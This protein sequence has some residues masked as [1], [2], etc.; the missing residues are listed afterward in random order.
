MKSRARLSAAVVVMA[1]ALQPL[2]T[3]RAAQPSGSRPLPAIKPAT[4]STFATGPASADAFLAHSMLAR[5][6]MP[7]D[8]AMRG[9][10]F[11]VQRFGVPL[12]PDEQEQLEG[13]FWW[14]VAFGVMDA[15]WRY[16]SSR[17]YRPR[18]WRYWGG[19]ATAAAIGGTVGA[20][21]GGYASAIRA[22]EPLGRW[23]SAGLRLYGYVRTKALNEAIHQG[24]S[25]YWQHSS[26]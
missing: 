12:G 4:T 8:A 17:E 7:E 9:V 20:F 14:S 1:L 24:Q 15:L 25:Y 22:A 21:S 6:A 2:W 19:M 26:Y 10:D 11:D 16:A 3:A 13:H 5:P 18:S 23:A